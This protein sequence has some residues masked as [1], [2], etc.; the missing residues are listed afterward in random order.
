M[1]NEK[2]CE[3]YW[4]ALCRRSVV[5]VKS[6]LG[7]LFQIQYEL[8]HNRETGENIKVCLI[9]EKCGHLQC[10]GSNVAMIWR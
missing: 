5:F 2:G 1:I 10:S 3:I 7:F 9:L 6:I 4:Y 8:Q